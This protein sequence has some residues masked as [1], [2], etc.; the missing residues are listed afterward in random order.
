MLFVFPAGPDLD[1]V[2][3]SPDGNAIARDVVVG[4]LHRL[5]TVGLEAGV[6]RLMFDS[7]VTDPNLHPVLDS[8]EGIDRNPVYLMEIPA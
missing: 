4:A 7:H 3:E 1:V 2:G 8:I 6:D 5:A